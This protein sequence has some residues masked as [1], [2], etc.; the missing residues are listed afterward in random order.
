MP[1]PFAQVMQRAQASKGTKLS[2][3]ETAKIEQLVAEQVKFQDQLKQAEVAYEK[4]LAER[5]RLAAENVASPEIKK[6]RAKKVKVYESLFAEREGIK[7]QLAEM[8]YRVNDITGVTAEGAHL[9]GKLAVN[10]IREGTLTLSDVVRKVREDVPA[11]TERDVYQSLIAKDPKKQAKARTETTKRIA[12]LKTQAN[13]LLKIEKAEQGIFDK[14]KGKM[15]RPEEIRFLQSKLRDLRA[16]AYKSGVHPARLERSLKTINE[17]QDQLANHYRAVR[18]AKPRDTIALE[19]TKE[20]IRLLRREMKVEDD[21][22]I[23]N[24]Q[25]RTGDF[26]IK[27]RPSLK[28]IPLALERKQIELKRARRQIRVA[29]DEMAPMTGRKLSVEAVNTLRTLKAFSEISAVLRQGVFGAALH[30]I[31]TLKIYPTSFKSFF[32]KY[33]AEKVDNMIR[34]ADHHYIREKSKL[35]LPEIGARPTLGEELFSA[36]LIEKVPGL[37]A[38]VKA[39]NR[40][41]ITHLNMLRAVTFDDFLIKVPNATHAELTAY[42]DWINVTS[43]RGNLGRAAAVANGLSLGI[44]APRF[45][46][47]RIQTPYMVFK[48]WKEPRIRKAIAKDMVGFVSVGMS[49]LILADLAGF[50]VSTDLRDPD[51]GKIRIGDTRVDIW[52]GFLQPVRVTLRVGLTVTDK[53]NITGKELAAQD[54]ETDPLELIERFTSYKLAPSLT[55]PLELIRGRTIVGEPVTP[56]QTAARAVLPMWLEDIADAYRLEGAG[57]ALGVGILTGHGVG[58]QTYKDSEYRTRRMIRQ[59]MREF[60]LIEA[61]RLQFEWNIRHPDNP[62]RSVSTN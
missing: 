48:Y 52:G 8:G 1:F 40:H 11:L 56:S 47:S 13:L 3:K 34:S 42:A 12:D 29:I 31:K 22:A 38:V 4:L 5:D 9:V 14:A 33:T 50:E 55:I 61:S 18:K 49:T 57:R 39:S 41:M 43:G 19:S 62:I 53:L 54:K 7:S 37:G 2:P 44:F 23:L 58:V 59:M 26:V 10:Y 27:E 21:L 24:E 32:S 28:K 20:K 6:A 35:F 36:R 25:L 51:F 16:Q 15:P 45:S 60:N 17:L 46:A 30:P